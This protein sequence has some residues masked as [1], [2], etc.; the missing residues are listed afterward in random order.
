LAS[1]AQFIPYVDDTYHDPG[2]VG[3]E[4]RLVVELVAQD[5]SVSGVAE[6]TKTGTG[7][8]QA[9]NSSVVGT[10]VKTSNSLEADLTANE[11]GV[12]SVTGNGEREVVSEVAALVVSDASDVTGIAERAIVNVDASPAAQESSASGTTVITSNG[13]GTP[14][15][16]NAT[17][18]GSGTT[19]RNSSGSLVAQDATIVGAA[20]REI[21]QVGTAAFKPTNNNVTTGLGLPKR[22]AFGALKPTDNNNVSGVA[23]RIIDDQGGIT[24]T[25]ESSSV[26]GSGN[27]GFVT[28]PAVSAQ[29]ATISGVAERIV[30][31]ESATL[32]SQSSTVVSFAERIITASGAPKPTS[33]N[34]VIGVA[35][36]VIELE[37]FGVE[38]GDLNADISS[39]SGTGLRTVVDVDA[40]PAAQSSSVSGV[41]E[42]TVVDV[43]AT[44]AA[45]SSVVS[46]I[47][48]RKIVALDATL[49]DLD[50]KV[51]SVAGDAER[52]VVVSTAALTHDD[53]ADIVATA[54]IGRLTSA[55]L[56]PTTNNVVAGVAERTIN[57][58]GSADLQPSANNTVTGVA[59]NKIV[60]SGVLQVDSWAVT[61]TA[62]RSIVDV[63]ATLAAQS[64]TI[65]TSVVERII[66]GVDTDLTAA[67]VGVVATTG[68][69][70]RSVVTQASALVVDDPSDVVGVAERIIVDVSTA[71]VAQS[72]SIET[73]VAERVIVDVDATPAAQSSTIETGIAER[74][75]VDVDTTL[76]AQSSTIE[77]G[78]AEREIRSAV[79]LQPTTNNVVAG[80]AERTIVGV[81]TDLTAAEVGL[82]V[83]AGNGERVVVVAN[84]NLTAS[85]VGASGVAGDV[86]RIIDDNG[87]NSI[88][89]QDATTVG[90]VERSIVSVSTALAAQHSSIDTGIGSRIIDD[91]LATHAFKPTINNNVSGVA[92]REIR[93]AVSLSVQSSTV[94]AVTE[95][96]ANGQGNL[97]LQPSTIAGVAER[98]IV[99]VDTDLTAAEVGV[100]SVT[101]NAERQ[102]N[103]TVS[104]LVID[105]ASDVTGV[106]ERIIVISEP[107]VFKGASAVIGHAERSIVDVDATPVAQPSTVSGVAERTIVSVEADLTAAEVGASGVAGVAEREI[108]DNLATHA[109]KPT[110]NNIVAGIA[111][112]EIRS[113]VTLSTIDAVVTGVAERIVELEVN[114]VIDGDVNAGPSTVNAVTKRTVFSIEA[115]LTAAEV[116]ASGVAGVAEREIDDNLATHALRPTVNNIVTGVAEREIRSAVTLQAGQSTVTVVPEIV[117]NGSGVLVSDDSIV[118]GV[119]ERIIVS[120][121]A[122]LTA[123]EIG[124]SAVVGVG[125]RVVVVAEGNLTA[126]EVGASGVAGVAEREI[127]D[128]GGLSV[129]AG[130]SSVSGVGIRT[131]KLS[132]PSQAI[133]Q[134]VQV[135]GVAERI[136]V[137]VEAD[138]TAAEVGVSVVVGA[139]EREID[140]Q[141]GNALVTADSI[142]TG[143]AERTIVVAT[144]VP[145]SNGIAVLEAQPSAVNAVTK[146]T[147]FAIEADLTAD[148]VGVANVTGIADRTELTEVIPLVKAFR[149]KKQPLSTITIRRPLG[150]VEV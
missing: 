21:T 129:E 77:T 2:Y 65:E 130:P 73:G 82:V 28:S 127:D 87:G 62:E 138:L 11:I 94:T 55:A 20:E 10:T 104:A 70:E 39:V 26:S 68:N 18:S 24:V 4:H 115:D 3:G 84:G 150:Q 102:I 53:D 79:V 128:Q 144:G 46:G 131:S 69:A 145:D 22:T 75:I 99:G 36:R 25:A 56:Q 32:Q 125:E 29:D 12:S 13:T 89:A 42:R 60:G 80:V 121:E 59:E 136:I 111:E 135:V 47:S 74:S 33:N 105:D 88:Q 137:A 63:D 17:V 139:G 50:A 54:N 23:E 92:E 14:K 134:N 7:T 85:E 97:N 95:I 123:A 143:L 93:S 83:V 41:A 132:G 106:A 43:D 101:G 35:E 44:P 38:D 81:D 48:E 5:A 117:S 66:V 149:I 76:A 122:D 52:K 133:A 19:T 86:E 49:D 90:V 27:Q 98:T 40:T 100:T 15:A 112:R 119:A 58:V 142:V 124:V 45:Q 31:S 114:G 118:S 108:D 57:Q 51:I 71:L 61:G 72:S 113:A 147:V 96:T 116:G 9:Q 109:L 110:I 37:I 107:T 16:Q 30:V 148:E 146:R 120:V 103:T 126:S 8:L 141:G 91:N 67:E 34:L 64:S 6:V 78:I 140:D 1:S